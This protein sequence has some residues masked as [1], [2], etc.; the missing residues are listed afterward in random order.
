MGFRRPLETSA[1]VR[2]WATGSYGTL[3][4]AFAR[5]QLAEIVPMLLQHFARS[6][7]PDAAVAAFGR[8]LAGLHGGGRLFSLLRPN[9][10]LIPPLALVRRPAP[11]LAR[12]PPPLPLG[13]DA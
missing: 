6:A 13:M 8:F 7:N 10:D 3:K 5:S 1:L 11:R 9:T 2:R 4:G 12:P